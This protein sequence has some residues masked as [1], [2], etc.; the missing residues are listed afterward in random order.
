MEHECISEQPYCPDDR[1]MS[2]SIGHH[3]E[4]FVG[5]IKDQLYQ[6]QEVGPIAKINQEI[7]TLIFEVSIGPERDQYWSLYY[8]IPE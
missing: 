7:L 1:A 8:I 5:W 4:S 2:D 6:Q 3:K